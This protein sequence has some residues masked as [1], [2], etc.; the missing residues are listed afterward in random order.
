[1]NFNKKTLIDGLIGF[2]LGGACMYI[3]YKSMNKHILLKFFPD[4][5]TE[6]AV[7][8]T[9]LLFAPFCAIM[10]HEL[11]HLGAGLFQ[12]FRLELFVVGF[13]GIKRAG[14][15]TIPYLNTNF[16][17]F[18]GVAAS[19]PTK[20]LAD[21]EL[22]QKYKVI[23][24]AGP[25]SSLIFA[26]LAWIIFYF[27]D[28]I[29]NPFLG[30]FAFISLGIFLA[31]TLPAQ[32]GIFFSDRKRYQR[33][34]DKGEVGKIELAFLQIVNQALLEDSC[35][36]LSLERINML[37]K[38][39][40]EIIIFW[41]YYFEYQYYKDNQLTENMYETKEKLMQY[42][43]LIPNAIWKSLEIGD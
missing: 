13:L 4:N 12:G 40:E 15:K 16:Q 35:K 29:L 19:S 39:E 42:K 36:N 27:G 28:T 31:T 30:L 41:A 3:G 21:K 33:L 37:K 25:I 7:F 10:L 1:M 5:N 43:P 22:I 9:S 2:I 18:G 6:A 24:L 26:V 17:Y 20:Q 38:D 34:N 8:Y 23:L 11:G 14:S 32:T